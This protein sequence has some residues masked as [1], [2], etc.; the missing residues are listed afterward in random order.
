VIACDVGEEK[1]REV[2]E[3]V[4][5]AYV[6]DAMDTKALK[7]SGIVNVDTAVVSIGEN[8]KSSILIVVKLKELGVKEIVAKGVNLLN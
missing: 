6:L 8:I 4:S 3:Y 1:V 2:S 5:L 7:E